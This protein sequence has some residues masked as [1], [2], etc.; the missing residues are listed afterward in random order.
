MAGKLICPKDCPRRCVS[1]N[2]HNEETCEQWKE[3]MDAVRRE[4]AERKIRGKE[5][6]DFRATRRLKQRDVIK[7]CERRKK[8][9]VIWREKT[10]RTAA[11]ATI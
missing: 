4:R 10:L 6:G 11:G 9:N 7:E 1:P 2:C 8:E 5:I 3:H